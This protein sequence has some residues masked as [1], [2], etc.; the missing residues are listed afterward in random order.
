MAATVL[1]PTR[2]IDRGEWLALRR[3]GIGGSD[4]AAVAGLNPYKSPVMVWLE[5]TGQIE[6]EE[7]T[8][9]AAYW[10][11]MLEDLVAKEFSLRTGLKVQRRNAILQH[12]EHPFMI[13]NLDRIIIDKKHGNGVLECK[14]A[15][16]YLKGSW[17][18]DRIPDSY[19]IQIQHYLAVTGLQYGYIA[20]LIGGNK[21]LYKRIERDEEIISYLIKIEQDFWRLVEA[22]TPP[23]FDGSPASTE[24]L[25][26]LYPEGKPE[27][28][29]LPNEAETL[30]REYE[31]AAE[32]ERQWAERKEEAA[33]KLR[34]MLGEHEIGVI[35]ERRVEWRTITSNR[36]DTRALQNDHPDIY[37][38]YVKP[39][40]YR[41][42]SIR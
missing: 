12:P 20:V 5:K 42:F 8:N 13:A 10:G 39:S 24:L 11:Q 23:A 40:T 14:T 17:A 16:E 37:A 2:D 35:G 9:E 15:S 4:A 22:G 6:P 38:Q 18:D 28:I 29:L 27:E 25:K 33:N 26:K 41:K 3:R 36:L 34:A 31:E 1:A 21:F 30:I 19:M 7:T 32:Y